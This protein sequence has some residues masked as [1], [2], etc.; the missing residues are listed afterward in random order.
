MRIRLAFLAML[1]TSA[2]PASI[3]AQDSLKLNW[4]NDYLTISGPRLPGGSITIHYME[5]FCRDGS[6]SRDWHETVIP[7]K[8]SSVSKAADDD[9]L[10]L[11]SRLDDGVIVRHIITSTVDSVEFIVEAVNPSDAPSRAHWAQP[12]MR[13]D[14]FVGVAPDRN[15]EAYL[16]RSFI[17]LPSPNG[18]DPKCTFLN[19]ITPWA[20]AARY[21]PG[22]VWCS[23]GV[24]RDD[25]NPRPLNVLTPANGLIGCVSADDKRLLAM[26]WEPWQELFQGV[27]VCLHSDFRIGGLGPKQRRTIRGKLYVLDNDP[28]MLLARY[29]KDFPDG[30]RTKSTTFPP[31]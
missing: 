11:E 5:A 28:D 9:R 18:G 12:C 14:R 13:V 22:Q 10:I 2:I 16:S 1:L 21:V 6:T 30:P 7:H 23:P 8:T 31:E 17:F 26:A 15:S 27:N 29:Q 25:V 3:A 20:K 24:P 4:A 19:R